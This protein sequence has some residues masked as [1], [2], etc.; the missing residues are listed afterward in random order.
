MVKNSYFS[1]LLIKVLFLA[2]MGCTL[3][4][5]KEEVEIVEQVR[6]LKTIT[7][8]EMATKQIRKFSGI[9]NAVDSSNLSFEVGGNVKTVHVDIGDRV[10]KGQILA[11]LDK[12]PYRLDVD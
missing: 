10:R 1:R 6:T 2:I 12:E 9:V 3:T 11:V 7:V 4:A 5:C 8:S